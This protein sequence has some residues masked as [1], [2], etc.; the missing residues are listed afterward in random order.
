ME[1]YDRSDK[2]WSR[3]SMLR[4]MNKNKQQK[5]TAFTNLMAKQ[6]EQVEKCVGLVKKTWWLTT[7]WT[8]YLYLFHISTEN[9]II[10]Q[11]VCICEWAWTLN[12]WLEN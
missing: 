12:N 6:I 3:Y 8:I 10:T 11:S 1:A 7:H 2:A 4:Y 9:I 5:H